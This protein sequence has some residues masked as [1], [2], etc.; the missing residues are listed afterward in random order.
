MKKTILTKIATILL[1]TTA[2][3]YVVVVWSKLPKYEDRPI[4][5]TSE[6]N[7]IE[8]PLVK[9]TIRT[10]KQNTGGQTE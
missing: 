7:D 10:E 2:T 1:I 6:I 8:K 5:Q 4:E 3:V 9:E